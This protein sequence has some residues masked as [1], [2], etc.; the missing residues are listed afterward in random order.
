M[1]GEHRFFADSRGWPLSPALSPEYRE[2]GVYF[3]PPYA[4]KGMI[5]AATG[6]IAVGGT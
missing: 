5:A 6:V 3:A 1:A 4:A 2:E